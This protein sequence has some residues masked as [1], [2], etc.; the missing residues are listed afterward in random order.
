MGVRKIWGTRSSDTIVEVA[1]A[2]VEYAGSGMQKGFSVVKRTVDRKGRVF[3]KWWF[4]VKAE[5]ALVA[6]EKK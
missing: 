2:V 1:K 5:E 4:I 3:S 6:L